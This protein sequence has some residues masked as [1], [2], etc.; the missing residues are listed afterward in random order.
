MAAILK[1]TI[2]ALLTSVTAGGGG[3][4]GGGTEDTVRYV[5]M[6]A[7]D[8]R[9]KLKGFTNLYKGKNNERKA[10]NKSQKQIKRIR[11]LK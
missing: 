9:Q 7:R 11:V 6:V 5:E 10:A 2:L 1:H 8:A 4:I 3:G